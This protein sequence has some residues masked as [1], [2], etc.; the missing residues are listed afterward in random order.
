V[1]GENFLRRRRV[2][3]AK[4]ATQIERAVMKLDAE[5]EVLVQARRRLLDAAGPMVVKPRKA[6]APEAVRRADPVER[7]G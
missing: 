6:K 4:R 2:G 7:A 5:I 1:A 3:M